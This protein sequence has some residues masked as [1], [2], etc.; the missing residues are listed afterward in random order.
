MAADFVARG[1]KSTGSHDW[2]YELALLPYT[3]FTC[4]EGGWYEWYIEVASAKLNEGSWY[5]LVREV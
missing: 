2:H 4:L 3:I 1:E 5:S